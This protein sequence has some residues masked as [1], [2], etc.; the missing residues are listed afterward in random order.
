ME[1]MNDTVTPNPIKRILIGLLV[2]GIGLLLIGK[3][4]NMISPD[5]LVYLYTWQA[6][7][8]AFGVINFMTNK[9]VGGIIMIIIGMAFMP[10]L[11][12]DLKQLI[13][14]ILLIIFGLSLIFF[15]RGPRAFRHHRPERIFHRVS[16]DGDTDYFEDLAIFGGSRHV[17]KSQ[18]FKGGKL[19]AIFGGGEF[20]LSGAKLA[21]SDRN[22]IEMVC[23]F[24]GM[25]L[26]VPADWNVHIKVVSLLGGIADNRQTQAPAEG[27]VKK[28]LYIRGVAI[29]GGGEIKTIG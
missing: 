16:R 1:T 6:L 4:M 3:N 7:L 18:S 17:I 14:P 26:A 28:T 10:G 13:I 5:V 9:R 15:R 22:V 19:V 21:D 23:V 2:I 25:S 12:L 24:G 8:I 20:D 29:F 27:E 11:S